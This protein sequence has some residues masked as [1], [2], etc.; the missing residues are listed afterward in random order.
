[1]RT[2]LY[3]DQ[4]NVKYAD[5][6]AVRFTP[7]NG[8]PNGI[9][10]GTAATINNPPHPLAFDYSA[11]TGAW[12]PTTTGTST[13]TVWAQIAGI[14]ASLPV[15]EGYLTPVSATPVITSDSI[16]AT[17]IYYTPFQGTWTLVHNGTQIIPYQ[18][19]QMALTLTTSQAASNIYDV[20]LAYNGGTPVIGTGPS[21]SAGTGG[22]ITA[23]SCA[24]GTGVG[25]AA[26]SR[27]QGVWTNTASMSLIWN[28]GSGNTTITVA[29]NQGIYLGSIFIDS[30]A[31]QVTCHRSYGLSRKFAIWNPYNRTPLYLKTGDTTGSTW[32][33][34]GSVR[35]INGNAAISLTAFSG[36]PEETFDLMYIQSL[37]PSGGGVQGN[38][39]GVNSISGATGTIGNSGNG[40]GISI[41]TQMIARYLMPPALGIQTIT[42]LETGPTSGGTWRSQEA[43]CLLSAVWRG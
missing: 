43:N 28:T 39:I 20:F 13:S 42:A 29:A 25:G 40:S 4:T 3:S 30:S 12:V 10:A 41:N 1:M 19:S 8:N 5:D 35:A 31:G 18:F 36:L 24:R 6:S 33:A 16:G 7:T 38:G 21:W 23:G 11:G 27:L 2:L 34:S 32:A 15:P 14:G 37:A 17:A 22:S 9:L 26:L